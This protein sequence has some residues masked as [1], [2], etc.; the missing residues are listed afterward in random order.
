[1][2]NKLAS[3]NGNNQPVNTAYPYAPNDIERE[4]ERE[5]EREIV[6][7]RKRDRKRDREKEKE[8]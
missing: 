7:D 6:R 1:M 4:R 5:R 3:S 2:P 8:R